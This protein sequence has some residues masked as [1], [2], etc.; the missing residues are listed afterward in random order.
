MVMPKPTSELPSA[1]PAPVPAEPP[2]KVTLPP[3]LEMPEPLAMEI[4]PVPPLEPEFNTT[5]SSPDD[6]LIVLPADRKISLLAASVKVALPPAVLEIAS[7]SVIEPPLWVAPVVASETPV[8]EDVV[9]VPAPVLM[10]TLVPAFNAVLMVAEVT[11]ELPA[12]T[13]VAVA[14]ISTLTGSS[15]QVPA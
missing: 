4:P 15:S 13:G 10:V 6:E 3:L 5:L 9:P 14:L 7:L 8:A 12:V 1:A 11:T 2:P